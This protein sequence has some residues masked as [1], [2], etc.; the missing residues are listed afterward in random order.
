MM[1]ITTA[2]LVIRHS[3]AL[4]HYYSCTAL[5][6]STLTIRDAIL[7]TAIKTLK[8]EAKTLLETYACDRN[9]PALNQ[10]IYDPDWQVV[11]TD[12]FVTLPDRTVKAR[13]PFIIQPFGSGFIAQSPVTQGM[14]LLIQQVGELQAAAT[15]MLP[16]WIMSHKEWREVSWDNLIIPRDH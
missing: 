8:K 9:Q 12:L 4:G 6:R 7:S 13:L 16:K 10:W 15:E 5:G 14:N 3:T 2:C 11:T 1:Q